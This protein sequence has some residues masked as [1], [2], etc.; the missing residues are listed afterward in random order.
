MQQLNIQNKGK[1]F[2]LSPHIDELTG[3]KDSNVKVIPWDGYGNDQ[4]IRQLITQEKPDAIS[5]YRPQVLDLV[6]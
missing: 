2:D 6:I 1:T 4:I 5:F 3:L